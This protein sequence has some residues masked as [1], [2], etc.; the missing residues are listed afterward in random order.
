MTDNEFGL[1]LI[2]QGERPIGT[3]RSQTRLRY[4]VADAFDER[5]AERRA[6]GRPDK[7][8]LCQHIAAK[9]RYGGCPSKRVK[10]KAESDIA[11]VR[12]RVVDGVSA[13]GL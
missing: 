4:I 1:T 6:E 3:G 10:G 7:A 12:S 13:S 2:G 8:G 9:I 11:I 5:A